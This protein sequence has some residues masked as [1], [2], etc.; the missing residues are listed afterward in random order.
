MVCVS[1]S[2]CHSPL[3]F[4]IIIILNITYVVLN[5]SPFVHHKMG[6]GKRVGIIGVGGLGHLAVQFSVKLGCHTTAISTSADK[7]KEVAKFGAQSFININDSK[8]VKDAAG[9]FDF[10]LSTIAADNINWDQYLDLLDNGWILFIILFC[11]P[12]ISLNNWLITHQSHT[13]VCMNIFVSI[14]I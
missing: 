10:L 9:T 11:P 3:N 8:Q 2:T 1:I 12:L 6:P 7:A 13:C 4:F 5:R 14:S